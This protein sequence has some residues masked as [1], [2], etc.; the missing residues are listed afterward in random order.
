MNP[1]KHGFEATNV[2]DLLVNVKN[3]EGVKHVVLPQPVCWEPR[4]K[5]LPRSIVFES[6][7][8]FHLLQL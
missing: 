3:C 5:A 2:Y 8:D 7:F 6:P 1:N 4:P